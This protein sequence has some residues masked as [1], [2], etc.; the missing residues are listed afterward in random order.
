[1]RERNL[2][3]LRNRRTQK[4]RVKNGVLLCFVAVLALTLS[5]CSSLSRKIRGG[6]TSQ[7]QGFI[8]PID[9]GSAMGPQPEEVKEVFVFVGP[10]MSAALTGI[11]VIRAL[12]EEGIRVS[13]VAGM[14]FGSFVAAAYSASGSLNEMEWPILQF[15]KDWVAPS[16]G[17]SRFFSSS[18]KSPIDLQRGIEKLFREKPLEQLKLPTWTFDIYARGEAQVFSR[19]PVSSALCV[20]LANPEWMDP[21][22]DGGSPAPLSGT[23]RDQWEST[24]LRLPVVWVVAPSLDVEATARAGA[25]GKAAVAIR[26]SQDVF[27]RRVQESRSGNDLEIRPSVAIRDY[28][29]FDRRSELVYAGKRDAKKQIGEWMSRLG[30]SREKKLR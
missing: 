7:P 21:C 6:D 14:E 9:A 16:G 28:F 25:E 11:G 5:A 19:G 17:I 2:K 23:F 12:S 24:G 4:L 1:M 8:G 29:D 15:K 27:L 13:V 30:W 3:H 22:P 10:G 18:K 26:R 20:A